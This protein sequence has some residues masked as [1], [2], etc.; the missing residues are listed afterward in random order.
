MVFFLHPGCK[1]MLKHWIWQRDGSRFLCVFKIILFLKSNLR[2][3]DQSLVSEVV[4]TDSFL[5]PKFMSPFSS[6]LLFEQKKN[7]SVNREKYDNS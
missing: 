6:D 7:T 4:Q 3:K 1:M 2:E 5:E